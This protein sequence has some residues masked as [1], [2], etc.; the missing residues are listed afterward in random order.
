MGLTLA[1]ETVKSSA[2]PNQNT[3]RNLEY[4]MQ[5]AGNDYMANEGIIANLD[6]NRPITKY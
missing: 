4:R 1:K 2:L 3:I 6:P 5:Q